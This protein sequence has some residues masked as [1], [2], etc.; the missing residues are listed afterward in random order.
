M[1]PWGWGS[2]L[3]Q[4]RPWATDLGWYKGTAFSPSRGARLGCRERAGGA[5]PGRVSLRGV[6]AALW[7]LVYFPTCWHTGHY[8]PL[9]VRR[10]RLCGDLPCLHL[11]PRPCSVWGRGGVQA[12]WLPQSWSSWAT[13]GIPAVTTEDTALP[14]KPRA[15]R[16]RVGAPTPHPGRLRTLSVVGLGL[17]TAGSLLPQA[18]GPP[19]V[20]AATP[21]P[22]EMLLVWVRAPGSDPA[23]ED[24]DVRAGPPAARKVGVSRAQAQVLTGCPV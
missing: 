10:P 18:G 21:I 22:A 19:W 23:R 1:V 24:A 9:Q 17:C 15:W 8:C 11:C 14:R 6:C 16:G 20:Q 3:H 4:G 13:E 7:A 5:G 12:I 2:P